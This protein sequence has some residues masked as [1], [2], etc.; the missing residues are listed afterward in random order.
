VAAATRPARP[1]DRLARTGIPLLVVG[2]VVVMVVPLPAGLLDLLI[3][4]NLS[5]AVVVLVTAMLVEDALEFSVFPALLLVTTL[6]RLSLNVSTTRLILLDGFAGRVIEA[7]GGFV[8]GGNLVVGLVIFLILVVIQFAVITAGAG[9]V[10]E[11]AARFTLDAM[12]GK[13]MAI[14]ADLNSGL[15]TEAEARR[16]R[17][18]IAREADFYGAMDGASKFVKG[19]AIAAVVIV[20]IN[21]LGGFAVG[22][23]QHHLSVGES[24]RR[25]ALLSVGDGLVS[26]IPALLI[27]VAAGI[28]VTRTA[29]ENDGGLG[30]DL[31][32]QLLQSRRVLGIAAAAVGFMAVLPGLPKIPFAALAAALAVAA[33]RRPATAEVRRAR[34]EAAAK[35]RIAAQ[36]RPDTPEAILAEIGV[37][38]LELELA[39]DLFDLVDQERGGNLLERVKAL[40][41]QI[42]SDLGLVVPLVRTRDNLMLPPS[43][44]VIRVHGVEVGRGEAPPGCVLV[45]ADGD[46]A[47]LPGRPTREPVFGLPAAWVPQE[48]SEAMES[49]GHV[50]V[51][52]GSVLVTHLS[53]VVRTHAADLLSRQDVQALVDVVRQAAPA[54]ANDIGTDALPL[55]EI[56]RVLRGLLAEGVPIRN[57]VRILEAVTAKVR[58]TRDPEALLEAARQALGPVICA[59]VAMGDAIHALTLDPLL[60]Q[61]LLEALRT[62]ESGSFLALDAVRTERLIEG[63]AEA[64]NAAE[65]AG[66]RPVILCSAQLRPALR[67][68]IAAGRP[69]LP[70]LSYAELS[71]NMTIEPVGV[72][73]LA[74]HAT[75]I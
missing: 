66:R 57:L 25:F 42:A 39:P 44:Y 11:V 9:R 73:N 22:V 65:A 51:D 13:Q 31:W 35:E 59:G 45:L 36:H 43:T 58:E 12:P 75:A 23:L 3:A 47:A 60:E 6:L 29:S 71:R 1:G 41:R 68:L 49:A 64:V 20:V 69:S 7:F 33:A 40:R 17:E 28:V 56:Q 50:V 15:I 48:L 2:I 37:E 38:P 53:E 30:A 52:R 46:P 24:I 26:Q 70:V 5:L 54:L 67:R 74:S 55:A 19:D 16:R 21:L 62:G 27:S 10:A 8:V 32:A 63:I 72:I 14:D 18:E 61:A 34:E 4:A